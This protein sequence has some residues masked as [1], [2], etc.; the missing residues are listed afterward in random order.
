MGKTSVAGAFLLVF[1]FSSSALG[2]ETEDAEIKLEIP[3]IGDWQCPGCF[4]F[5]AQ[6][7]CG[8]DPPQLGQHDSE[9]NVSFAHNP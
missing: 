3:C 7:Q 2:N 4:C 6:C 9:P 8:K 5:N 1:L